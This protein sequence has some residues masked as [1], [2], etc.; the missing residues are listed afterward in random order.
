MITFIEEI[1]N[2][3]AILLSV[4]WAKKGVWFNGE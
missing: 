1:D 3:I 4:I 2:N